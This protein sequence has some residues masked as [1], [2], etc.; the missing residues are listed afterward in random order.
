ML[1][2][3]SPQQA[4]V[5]G[6]LGLNLRVIQRALALG[7]LGPQVLAPPLG[8]EL[9]APQLL[10]PL[11]QELEQLPLALSPKSRPLMAAL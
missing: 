1:G 11:K 10:V 6:F 8:L 7:F 2:L 4:L 9:E 3:W 5:L